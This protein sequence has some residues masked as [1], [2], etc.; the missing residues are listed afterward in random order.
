LRVKITTDK[1]YY[2]ISEPIFVAASH[3]NTILIKYSHEL[4]QF[5]T[6]FNN[7]LS[8]EYFYLRVEGGVK[9][10][11]IKPESD[12]TIFID[13]N[14]NS[15]QLDGEVYN[16]YTHTFGDCEGIPEYIATKLNQLL[17]LNEIFIDNV[18]Y[19]KNEGAKFEKI[20]IDSENYPLAN[21]KVD[22]LQVQSY[23]EGVIDDVVIEDNIQFEFDSTDNLNLKIQM[24]HPL[25]IDISVD[26]GDGTIENY[27]G[28]NILLEHDY[29][30]AE[31]F[32]GI[33]TCS[34]WAAIYDIDFGDIDGI[35]DI[36]MKQ[37][38]LNDKMTEIYG[39]QA[40]N[41]QLV[42]FQLFRQNVDL[43]LIF[44]DG[45]ALSEVSVNNLLIEMD[46]KINSYF[47]L[48]IINISGG[49]S[50]APTGLGITAK[51][52]LIAKGWNVATN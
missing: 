17:I 9:E 7:S 39:I 2:F 18:R 52:S 4:N 25:S 26:W 50:A 24:V 19:K 45:N 14:H 32:D 36:G 21:Y 3:E 6:L 47:A 34:N 37:F 42:N 38:I 20:E 13:Q 27:T 11:D 31:N 1:I 48:K 8:R 30:T 49:T 41:T 51:N 46:A 5:S 22:L 15:I 40:S 16:I 12:N 44:I 28:S 10:S 23:I 35:I 29:L 43:H 33:I